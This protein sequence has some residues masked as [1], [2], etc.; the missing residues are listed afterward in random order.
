[1][2]S[3][4]TVTK[5]IEIYEECR[6]DWK[7]A[8]FDKKHMKGEFEA[9]HN[10]NAWGRLH[11]LSIILGKD[12]CETQDLCIELCKKQKSINEMLD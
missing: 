10:G 3:A 12:L 9:M 6:K 8:E 4:V 2:T 11:A 5:I 7:R 1:M